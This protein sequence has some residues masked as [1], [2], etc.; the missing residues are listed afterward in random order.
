VKLHRFKSVRRTYEE[1]G[2]SVHSLQQKYLSNY[3]TDNVYGPAPEPLS[4]YL[5][6]SNLLE[7][8]ACL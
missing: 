5:D 2:T 6:V 3:I 8:T 7:H 1:V 4:N